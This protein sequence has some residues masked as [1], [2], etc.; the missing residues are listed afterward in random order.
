MNFIRPEE[1]NIKMDDIKEHLVKAEEC[2]KSARK[3][4]R[5][6]IILSIAALIINVLRAILKSIG[7][8]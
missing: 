5:Q 1:V 4:S 7:M 3:S 6:A 8:L 2:A